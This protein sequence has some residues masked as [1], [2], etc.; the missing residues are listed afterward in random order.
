VFK[1]VLF[2]VGLL[3]FIT[4]V[5]VLWKDGLG[6]TLFRSSR[7]LFIGSTIVGTPTG[8]IG[9]TIKRKSQ[10]RNVI[11]KQERHTVDST[12][13]HW[14][15]AVGIFILIIS[16]FQIRLHR[17][18]AGT[19]LH[20][21]GLFL[22]LLFGTYFISDFFVSKK[23]ETLLPD[24]KDIVDGTLKK[25]LLHKKSKE[26]GKYLSSQKS[27]FLAFAIIG[28]QIL[29]SGVIK[30]LV[31]YIHIPTLLIQIAT[32]VHDISAVLFG[33]I[34]IIHVFLVLT[35]R[36]NRIL[37]LSWFT[38]KPKEEPIPEVGTSE[39]LVPAELEIPSGIPAVKTEN[40][41]TPQPEDGRVVNSE[42]RIEANINQS[43]VEPPVEENPSPK[44]MAEEAGAPA[45]DP[46]EESTSTPPDEYEKAVDKDKPGKDEKED[47][48]NTSLPPV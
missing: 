25:Y 30:L 44:I 16:G 10:S 48:D 37:L 42:S 36:M 17:G 39:N 38:G 11:I 47:T 46:P 29:I 14:G 43:P 32:Q 22:T 21:L 13:E 26:T 7:W 5:I 6:T 15:T 34:L 1:R 4:A 27:S 40:V 9:A 23:A 31:F 35:N 18:L 45:T 41:F 19:N 24:M 20:F 2:L 12:M 3:A 33:L 28:S 8:I